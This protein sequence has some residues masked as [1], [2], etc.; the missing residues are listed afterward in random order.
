[1]SKKQELTQD[2]NDSPQPTPEER[3]QIA[4]ASHIKPWWE[5][6]APA[7]ALAADA[8]E[9]TQAIAAT[10]LYQNNLKRYGDF[11]AY[12]VR[13]IVETCEGITLRGCR[14][15]DLDA[16]KKIIKDMAEE[17]AAYHAW[18]SRAVEPFRATVTACDELRRACVEGAARATSEAP[19]MAGSLESAV[20][21]IVD[22]W[23]Q[24][25]WDETTGQVG[26]LDPVTGAVVPPVHGI[27]R[28]G[29]QAVADLS[30]TA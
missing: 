3:L 14:D 20:R 1:M 6:Y 5:K 19:L 13:V 15:D 8:A 17:S 25:T 23:H 24:P 30:H 18:M 22:K 26:I 28:R 9:A 4:A 2:Q 21:F 10:A 16:M 29:E 11:I 12:R 7:L 27:L